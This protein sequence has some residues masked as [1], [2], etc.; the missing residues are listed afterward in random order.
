MKSIL[1]LT[2][3][4]L[5][6]F[7]IQ[8]CNKKETIKPTV[9]TIQEAVFASGYMEQEHTCNIASMA[10]GILLELPV[11]EG[12]IVKKGENIATLKSTVQVNQLNDAKVSYQQAAKAAATDAPELQNIKAQINQAKEQLEF[13][14]ENYHRYKEL[15]ALKSVSKLD[16]EKIALQYIS[17]QNSLKSL[18][19][20][21]EDLKSDL[22]YQ[23]K[24]S[25]IQLKTQKDL[26]NDY[27]IQT[28]Q[29]GKIINVYKKQGE[30]IRKGEVVA[31]VARGNFMVKLYI[32]ED[33]IVKIKPGQTVHVNLNTYPDHVFEAYVSKIYPGFNQPEQSYIVEAE[34]FN[35]PEKMFNGTQ[36]QAN[37]EIV[38]RENVMVVPTPFIKNNQ[39]VM[40]ED[41]EKKPV[42]IGAKTKEWTEIISGITTNDIIIK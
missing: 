16:Y 22:A 24:R 42:Q 26:L 32:A 21:Y 20:T 31:Q 30:L 8:S 9:K 4:F 10:D 28:P 12:Q 41:G 18:Q 29:E 25:Q 19:E 3:V 34:F 40:L 27:Q 33:D 11:K 2:L 39:F 7:G 17:S 38:K 5:L 23:A 35:Y 37:I 1:K 15:Y 13:D 6:I 36:L 14:T